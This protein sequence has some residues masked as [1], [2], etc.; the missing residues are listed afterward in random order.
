MRTPKKITPAGWA[1]RNTMPVAI[2]G[3]ILKKATFLAICWVNKDIGL[4][5]YVAAIYGETPIYDAM[6]NMI[7]KLPC[8]SF[9]RHNLIE[10]LEGP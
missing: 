5:Q 3:N 1:L 8:F 7:N 4:C 9:N 2:I 10:E 6:N